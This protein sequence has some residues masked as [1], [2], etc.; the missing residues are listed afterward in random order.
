MLQEIETERQIDADPIMVPEYR[1]NVSELAIVTSHDD[2]EIAVGD[3]AFLVVAAFRRH[4]HINNVLT[5]ISG[6]NWQRVEQAQRAILNPLTASRDLTPLARNIL[7]LMCADRGVTGRILKPYFRGLLARILSPH[8]AALLI[9]RISLLFL[10][11]E[12]ESR[13]AEGMACRRDTPAKA[14]S[15]ASANP[16]G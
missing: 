2:R 5:H 13:L 15:E 10:E 1:G 3:L 4:P 9:D 7:D 12:L 16:R 14:W 11:L 6:A 8:L